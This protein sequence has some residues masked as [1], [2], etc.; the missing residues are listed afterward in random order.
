MNAKTGKNGEPTRLVILGEPGVGKSALVVRYLTKR[1]IWEY[2]STLECTYIHQTTVDDETTTLEILDSTCSGDMPSAVAECHIRSADGFLIV[3]SATDRHSFEAVPAIK[4]LLDDQR[5]ARNV[6]CVVVANKADLQHQRRVT[7]AEGERVAAEL[8]CAFFETSASDGGEDIA[9][10]FHE[11]YREV[12]R[13]KLLE[14]KSRR[15]SSAQQVKQVLNKV[16]KIQN[17]S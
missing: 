11:L 9:E 8:A 2:D 15:R 3:Y 13:R 17:A 1:F 5:R 7:T 16:F 14:G 10:A 4:R 6:S 12:K